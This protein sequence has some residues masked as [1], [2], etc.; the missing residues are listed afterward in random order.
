[1]TALPPFEDTR[2]HRMEQAALWLQRMHA[3]TADERVVD[4]WLDW[5]Q[6]DPLN[7]QAFDEIAAIWELG[8][9]LGQAPRA[10][11]IAEPVRRP[12]RQLLAA[13]VAALGIAVA[14]SAW[15]LN[16]DA[17]EV[18]LTELTSPVGR[19]ST[20]TLADG[21]VLELGG[22]THVTVAIGSDERRV[23]LHAGELYVS[24]HHEPA[25]PFS[26]SVDKLQVIATGTAFNVLR[27]TGHTTVTVAE[28]SVKALYGEQDAIASN[29]QLLQTGQQ[30][31]LSSSNGVIVR[32]ADL[33]DVTAWRS[34]WLHFKNEPL[35]EVIEAV[36]RYT[37]RTIAIEGPQVKEIPF[38]TSVQ[39]DSADR[40]RDWKRGLR[41]L[42]VTVTERADGSLLLGPR[43]GTRSD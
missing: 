23:T 41:A 14:G 19:N 32:Q 29:V 3:A 20:Y 21:S 4:A 35:V 8:G 18:L 31:V 7:Q 30:L 1:M 26:V 9:Q 13:A 17:G 38:T 16:R 15:W 33:H 28:G 2:L 27:T 10:A 40:I 36:N 43:S 25:R 39:I 5:C 12:R 6:R 22:G 37:T 24:V 11:D 42:P 34:G